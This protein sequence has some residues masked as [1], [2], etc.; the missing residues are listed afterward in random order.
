MAEGS[1]LPVDLGQLPL[2]LGP[3]GLLPQSP[4]SLLAQLL[5][6]VAK[7]NPGYTANL[8]GS[9]IEDISST[10]VAAMVLIDQMR[11]EMLNSITPRGCNAFVLNQLGQIYGVSVGG[12]TNTSVYVIFT[13]FDSAGNA[14]PGFVLAKGFTISDG[15]YQY[16][17][18][19]GGAT[20]TTG[21]TPPLF[22]L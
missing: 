13:V 11:V 12:S 6:L 22:A 3:Q 1:D 19:D 16:Q 18:V 17:L 10:D 8:P 14:V 20:D 7:T 15:N 4:A 2:V 9:L 5:A 21:Q